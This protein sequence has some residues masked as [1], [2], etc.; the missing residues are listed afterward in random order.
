MRDELL[1]NKIH[2]V[3]K[4][5]DEIDEMI[6]TQPMAL[7]LVDHK[8]SDLYHLIENNELS[9]E[10]SI[11]VVKEI[12]EL[13]IKRRRLNNEY[14]LENVFN[15]HK[16]KLIGNNTRQ[17]LLSEIHSKEKTLNQPYKNRVYKEDEIKE[18]IEPKK[19]RGRPKK[20]E[21]KNE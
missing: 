9:D 17:F 14:E 3:T 4:L 15:A 19:K 5:L 20:V 16:N 2:E 13:R 1:I 18:L 12:H 21:V 11:K 7:Q 10:A 6:K 8:L